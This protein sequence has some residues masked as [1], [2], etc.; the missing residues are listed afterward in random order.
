MALISSMYVATEG[1]FGLAAEVMEYSIHVAAARGKLQGNGSGRDGAMEEPSPRSVLDGGMQHAQQ[2]TA[3]SAATSTAGGA[4]G[5]PAAAATQCFRQREHPGQAAFI[6]HPDSQVFY[7]FLPLPAEGT[8]AGAAGPAA[9]EQL[10][11]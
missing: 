5:L 6:L 4:D 7:E 11:R 9:R 8:S 2:G 3:H 10:L 1:S